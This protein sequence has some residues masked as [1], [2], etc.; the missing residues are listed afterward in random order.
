MAS[1]WA[2]SKHQRSTS[3]IWYPSQSAGEEV[4]VLLQSSLNFPF[5][6]RDIASRGANS[7]FSEMRYTLSEFRL[8][9][10]VRLRSLTFSALTGVAILSASL[11]CAIAAARCA[12]DGAYDASE[13]A[14]SAFFSARQQ[15]KFAPAERNYPLAS[16][17][18]ARYC[19]SRGCTGQLIVEWTKD[20]QHRLRLLRDDI[21]KQENALAELGFIKIA[22]LQME[23]WLYVRL[24]S[25]DQ[26]AVNEIMRKI[27]VH[28]GTRSEDTSWVASALSTFDRF[29]K[30][31]ATYAMEA[32]QHLLV[33][34]NLGLLRHWNVTAPVYRFGIPGHWTAGLENR[35]TCERYRFDLNSRASARHDLHL[36]G[37]DPAALSLESDRNHSFL[38]P[39]MDG[40]GVGRPT[41]HGRPDMPPGG[42]ALKGLRPATS[43]AP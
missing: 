24:R 8:P 27:S 14:D 6:L 20:E 2:S 38:L 7:V 39:G 11:S 12:R 31:C 35:E 21:V 9:G 33:L 40:A 34:A 17:A 26:R 23:T 36:K 10:F 15:T 25:L 43:T 1:N 42:F 13:I 4:A 41:G 16:N 37:K 3:L 30:E 32:T 29:D 19:F 22:V 28:Y 18:T 5:G